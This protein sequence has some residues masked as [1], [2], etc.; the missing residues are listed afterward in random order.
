MALFPEPVYPGGYGGMTVNERLYTAN[1]LEQFD[2]AAEQGDRATMVSLL[3][4]V[5][6]SDSDAEKI[7]VGIL[8]RRGF[9]TPED[10]K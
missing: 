3:R 2:A 6:I 5:E 9:G 8:A 10:S 1:T 7:A 4:A